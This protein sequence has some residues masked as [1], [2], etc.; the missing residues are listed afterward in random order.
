[1]TRVEASIHDPDGDAFARESGESA[2]RVLIGTHGVAAH[3]GYRA[4]IERVHHANR[5]NG[6]HKVR[7]REG[8]NC[9]VGHIGCVATKRGIVGTHDQSETSQCLS[10]LPSDVVHHESEVYRCQFTR[11]LRTRLLGEF[12]M[13]L[14]FFRHGAQ[15]EHPRNVRDGLEAR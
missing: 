10:P 7:F 11:W 6:H 12:W 8:V 15:A 14:E 2:G 13:H 3:K 1:M 4:V 5:L 9:L